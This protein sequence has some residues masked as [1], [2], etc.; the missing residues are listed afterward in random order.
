MSNKNT[1]R[2]LIGDGQNDLLECGNVL[3]VSHRGHV[4]WNV[5]IEALTRAGAHFRLVASVAAR[6]EVAVIEP[7]QRDVKHST[8]AK[9]EAICYYIRH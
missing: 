2:N 9:K 3:G 7:M 4:P 8:S 1:E 6:I 5:H